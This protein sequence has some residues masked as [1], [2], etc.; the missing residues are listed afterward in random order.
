MVAL[1]GPSGAG[2]TTITAL[3][4]RVCTTSTS[5]AVLVGGHDVREVTQRV[6]ARRCGGRHAR[7][8]TCSTTPSAAN[9]PLRPTRAT[10][11]R[12]EQPWPTPRSR[13]WCDPLPDGLDTV[14]GE[15]G[16]R[17]SGGE[18]QRLA[19]ARLLLKQPRRR[20]ARRGD[21]PPGLR[22]RGGGATRAGDR[23]AGPHVAGHRPSACPPFE[24]PTRS[25]SSMPD[26]SWSAA[27]T[28]SCSPPVA[29]TPT[30]T[31]PSSPTPMTRRWTSPAD[32]LGRR[33][34]GRLAGLP[35]QEVVPTHDR[36]C[37]KEQ[38]LSGVGQAAD[39]QRPAGAAAPRLRRRSVRSPVACTY[40]RYKTCE[41][42]GEV[43][44]EMVA[45]AQLAVSIWV[46]W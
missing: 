12:S 45:L 16:Y 21:G 35:P 1:V 46:T 28:R 11:T 18:K 38:P 26:A 39:P 24:R 29:C 44:R 13:T 42:P 2:K 36:D 41:Q 7:T 30:C 32:C 9:L 23:T 22:E 14:V 6:A 17:L 5:G 31:E 10:E 34:V 27:P 25:W 4:S 40:G 19:L 3:V 15:R 8:H 20:R 37:R 33:F 43:G